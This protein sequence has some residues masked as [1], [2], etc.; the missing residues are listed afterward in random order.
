MSRGTPSYRAVARYR[1]RA[2]AIAGEGHVSAVLAASSLREMRHRERGHDDAARA[3]YHEFAHVISD[4]RDIA[5][6][7]P[8]AR[9]V[10]SQSALAPTWRDHDIAMLYRD[11][12]ASSRYRG[13]ARVTVTKQRDIATGSSDI[14][15]L[16]ASMSSR[17]RP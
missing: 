12:A 14:A 6:R 4:I 10:I 9:L 17:A 16:R 2:R 11:D 8:F 3:R 7:H 15:G 1:G 13:T 5:T